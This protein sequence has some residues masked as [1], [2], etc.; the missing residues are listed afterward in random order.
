MDYGPSKVYFNGC[1]YYSKRVFENADESY[2]QIF[3]YDIKKNTEE[4]VEGMK[5]KEEG[6]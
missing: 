3:K 6:N 2:L 4:R 1:L 5:L